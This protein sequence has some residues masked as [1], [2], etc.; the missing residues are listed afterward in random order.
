[1]WFVIPCLFLYVCIDQNALE[2]K[3]E[4]L[5]GTKKKKKNGQK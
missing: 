2:T 3:L 4:N 1:M 5:T